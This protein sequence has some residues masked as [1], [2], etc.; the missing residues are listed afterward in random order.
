VS[1][2]KDAVTVQRQL[3]V[4][5][6]LAVKQ[7]GHVQERAE[8]LLPIVYVT[9]VTTR[10]LHVHSP[11]SACTVGFWWLFLGASSLIRLA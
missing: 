2:G 4:K 11:N 5:R 3:N 9:G 1:G 8:H 10:L 7:F 6:M